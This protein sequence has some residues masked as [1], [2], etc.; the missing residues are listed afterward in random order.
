M[1]YK[2]EFETVSPCGAGY[3]FY[4][5]DEPIC[6]PDEV[7]DEYWSKVSRDTDNPWQQYQSLKKWVETGEQLIRNVNLWKMDSEPKWTLVEEKE[8]PSGGSPDAVETATLRGQ[9]NLPLNLRERDL[10][11]YCRGE[12][13][14]AGLV[15]DDEYAEMLGW[16]S[17]KA[18]G[19]S[20]AARRL[21]DYNELRA[22]I[23]RLHEGVEL[24]AAFDP[25]DNVDELRKIA[26]DLLARSV[27]Q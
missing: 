17:A 22:E 1:I 16:S 23:D 7:P 20:H 3:K 5:N 11:R 4:A 14:V 19:G 21:E 25:D 6:K 9:T 15:T 18:G 10:L 26:T 27:P 24:I 2:L 12:L 13:H 8:T